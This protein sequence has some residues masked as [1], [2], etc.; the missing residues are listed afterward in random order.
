MFWRKLIVV[1]VLLLSLLIL[2]S[3]SIRT[4][5]ASIPPIGSF[6]SPFTG[7][8]QQS[9]CPWNFRN[10]EIVGAATKEPIE[11]IFDDRLVP[12][13]FA[14]NNEDVA[15]AQGYLHAKYRLF[16]M[17]IAVRSASGNL[18]EI[19]GE[20]TLQFDLETRRKGFGLG[21][22]NRLQAWQKSKDFALVEA[23]TKG[24][25]AYIECLKP[26]QYPL[27]FKLLNYSPEPWTPLKTAYMVMAMSRTLCSK[28]TDIASSNTLAKLGKDTFDLLFP[29]WNPKQSAI[30]PSDQST[31]V[32]PKAG[33]TVVDSNAVG[34]YPYKSLQTPDEGIGSNNWAVAGSKT[35]SGHPILCN[36]PHLDLSLPSIWFEAQYTTPEFS[37]YGVSIPGIPFNL[38]GFNEYV[39]WGSTNV[40]QDVLDW[41]KIRWTN[42]EKTAYYFDQ[43][44]VPVS[45]RVETIKVKGS[46][47]VVDSVKY[48]TWGP[49][50]YSQADNSYKDLAMHWLA[51]EEPM[52]N[53][54]STFFDLNRA[55]NYT[56]YEAA[57]RAYHSPA[58][59]LVFASKSGDIALRVSGQLP[60]KR[61]E[62]G[63]FIEDG[64]VSSNRWQG[65]I[66]Q[67]ANPE[68]MN[69]PRGFVASANQHSTT[70]DYPYYYNGD[71]D[72]YRGRILV[73]S[74]TQMGGIKVEDMMQLQQNN[75]SI[76]AEEALPA[77]LMN[78]DRTGID[79]SWEARLGKLRKWNYSFDADIIEPILFDLWYTKIYDLTWDELNPGPDSIP[80]L[81]PESWRTI[82]LLY[83]QPNSIFWDIQK[84]YKKEVAS[85]IVLEAFRQA[86]NQLDGLLKA[87]KKLSWYKYRKSK[88]NHIARIP[89]FSIDQIVNGGYK[90]ALN[91]MK[92][93][94]GPSWRMVVELG[95]E[96][97]AYGIYPGGQSGNPGSRFYSNM[98]SDWEKGKYNKLVM[99][100]DKDRL[101]EKALL[102]ILIKPAN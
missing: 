79:E 31:F 84:T 99:T 64:S 51:L 98:V 82:A 80:L 74:L 3:I 11:I 95:P 35:A 100:R 54:L 24:V 58:Q 16:Q 36:D 62:Q 34:Y 13:V 19:L 30:V 73:R 33:K 26:Q 93:K 48:T 92:E 49:V 77:M 20:K 47:D 59:N 46:A 17:D 56:E 61:K 53:D 18:S 78:L 40:S 69:P 86:N 85:D 9:E 43:K 88:I 68:I 1:S 45:Y 76:E 83:E 63:R 7:F 8:W 87:D 94:S 37:T 10:D 12:H 27:E 5:E 81:K 39:A 90:N 14:N 67:L 41:Y 91:A 42:E 71:F 72:D 66:P 29:E 32:I 38:I 28:E 89:A 96:T 102:T 23:Y 22:E 52:Q 70:P 65:F 25:N 101:R 75:H 15:Y 57:V 44:S 6:L 55:K 60:L 97:N 4:K 2:F 21:A 50:V